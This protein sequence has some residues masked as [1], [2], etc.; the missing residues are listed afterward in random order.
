MD[1]AKILSAFKI[2]ERKYKQQIIT[3]IAEREF[4]S[5][6]AAADPAFNSLEKKLVNIKKDINNLQNK[7]SN[8]I[9]DNE[10]VPTSEDREIMVEI[11]DLN[12]DE[13][14]TIEHLNVLSEMKIVYLFKSLEITMKSLIQSAYPNVNTKEFYQWESMMNYFKSIDIIVSC[15]DGYIEAIEL[16]KVNNSIKHNSIINEDI[17]KINEFVSETEFTYKNINLFYKRI[18]PKIKIFTK[19]LGQAIVND[20]FVFDEN[21]LKKIG[22]DFRQ[23]MDCETIKKLILEIDK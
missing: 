17:K 2:E 19:Q 20:L 7:I 22:S 9:D 14:W 6:D 5:Y 16:R 23:R 10:G 3:D 4:N 13:Y 11:M 15:F 12:S 1:I 8:Y 21:R 18:Y